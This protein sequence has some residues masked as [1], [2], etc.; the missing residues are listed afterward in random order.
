MKK[1]LLSFLI[2]TLSIAFLP[3][4]T[5]AQ[6]LPGGSSGGYLDPMAPDDG[7]S[8]GGG[9]TYTTPPAYVKSV[10]RNNGNATSVG[11]TAEARLQ[12]SK[13]FSGNVTL[14]AVK[15][16]DGSVSYNVVKFG[17]WGTLENGYFSYA[18]DKNINPAK[19][20]MFYFSGP[21]GNFAIPETN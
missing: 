8:S 9:V 18:L 6:E 13:G 20:L 10:K 19:K 11:G 21:T 5:F 7:I 4:G 1:S 14:L 16:L 2:L 15:S 3:K 17:G 12:I